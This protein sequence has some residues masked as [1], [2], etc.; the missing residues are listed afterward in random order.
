M[1]TFYYR[2]KYKKEQ[3]LAVRCDRCGTALYTER[4][5]Q[6]FPEH[7]TVDAR[8]AGWK[9]IKGFGGWSDYCPHCGADMRGD[10]NV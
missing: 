10:N 8:Q 5:G 6:E 3:T 7:I 4:T 9:H 2:K 1:S